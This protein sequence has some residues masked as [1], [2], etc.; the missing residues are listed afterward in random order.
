M[1]AVERGE[2]AKIDENVKGNVKELTGRKQQ[3]RI[4][5]SAFAAFEE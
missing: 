2:E 3:Q 5:Q 4:V 1:R